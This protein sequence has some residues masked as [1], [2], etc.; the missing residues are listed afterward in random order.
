MRRA[1]KTMNTLDGVVLADVS[2][3]RPS[4]RTGT[5][6][7]AFGRAADLDLAQHDSHLSPGSLA[8]HKFPE[9]LVGEAAAAAAIWRSVAVQ[10]RGPILNLSV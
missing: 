8:S 2:G 6:W 1:E 7:A 9:A 5:G 3:G 10:V 4:A